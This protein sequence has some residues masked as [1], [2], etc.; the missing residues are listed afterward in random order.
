VVDA[1]FAE[2]VEVRHYATSEISEITGIEIDDPDDP[3]GYA[4]DRVEEWLRER[5]RNYAY[6]QSTGDWY[7]E[8]ISLAT[9]KR[10]KPKGVGL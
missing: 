10:P 6:Y 9:C 5:D 8:V 4:I 1:G 3:Y 7:V 2:I